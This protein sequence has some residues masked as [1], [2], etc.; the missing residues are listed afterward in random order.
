MFGKSAQLLNIE[1]SFKGR[2]RL[3]G[4]KTEDRQSVQAQEGAK[5]LRGKR[6]ETSLDQYGGGHSLYQEGK[7]R[8][9]KLK[10]NLDTGSSSEEWHNENSYFRMTGD[11]S[12]GSTMPG[13]KRRQGAEEWRVQP[14][15]ESN[16]MEQQGTDLSQRMEYSER[17]RHKM[18]MNMPSL[19]RMKET[20][21]LLIDHLLC[22][23]VY[24]FYFILIGTSVE[25]TDIVTRPCK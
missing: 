17:Q 25:K 7:R 15:V 11:T 20:A 14:R 22:Y 6:N 21:F 16:S 2:V 23:Q 3:K 10:R 5:G 13:L 1:L 9:Q 24:V 19:G 12:S 8:A 4:K 18:Q